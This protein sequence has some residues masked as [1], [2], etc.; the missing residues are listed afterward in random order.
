MHT[1]QSSPGHYRSTM[2]LLGKCKLDPLLGKRKPPIAWG[3]PELA[4]LRKDIS[5]HFRVETNARFWYRCQNTQKRL[6]IQHR[7]FEQ[8]H[9]SIS[10][11]A[12]RRDVEADRRDVRAGLVRPL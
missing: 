3:K 9:T 1:V 10:Y 4:P 8:G 2:I 7:D 5:F 12:N 6:R 11:T